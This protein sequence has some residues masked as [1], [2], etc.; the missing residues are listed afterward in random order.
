MISFANSQNYLCNSVKGGSTS[1]RRPCCDN[2]QL[3]RIFPLTP[4]MELR[5]APFAICY[6]TTRGA[7]DLFKVASR[8]EKNYVKCYHIIARFP[9]SAWSDCGG[10]LQRQQR[11]PPRPPHPF[12]TSC[13]AATPRPLRLLLR[14]CRGIFSLACRQR[15]GAVEHWHPLSRE[16]LLALPF[17]LPSPCLS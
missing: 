14:L 12:S 16:P 9:I 10:G 15:L 8:R 6:L 1:K 3:P 13:P 4:R 5:L 2:L 11:P 7:L 17:L